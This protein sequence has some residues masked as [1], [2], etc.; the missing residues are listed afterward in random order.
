M[1]M[2]KDEKQHFFSKRIEEE[3]KERRHETIQLSVNVL[4]G[5]VDT[6]VWMENGSSENIIGYFHG[7]W[8]R[9]L[10]LGYCNIKLL[11]RVKGD[12]SNNA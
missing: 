8:N 9:L 2:T 7:Y 6:K 4:A 12:N 10:H 3:Q 11:R 1:I 5:C